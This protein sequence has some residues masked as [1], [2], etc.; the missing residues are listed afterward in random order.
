[1]IQAFSPIADCAFQ[2]I[3]DNGM[4]DKIHIVRKRSTDMSVGEGNL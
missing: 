1:M 3:A 2:V 4:S